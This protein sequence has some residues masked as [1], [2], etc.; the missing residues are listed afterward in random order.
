ME[1]IPGRVYVSYD[2]GEAIELKD[3][4]DE[5]ERHY[6]ETGEKQGVFAQLVLCENGIEIRYRL[7]TWEKYEPISRFLFGDKYT[8]ITI[9]MN[10]LRDS[11]YRDRDNDRS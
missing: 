6:R 3:V 9:D 1:S 4:G 11:L 2:N 7:F 8:N 5:L 10:E